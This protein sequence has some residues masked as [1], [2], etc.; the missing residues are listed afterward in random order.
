MTN[1]TPLGDALA[2][3][4]ETVVV[5]TKPNC[6]QCNATYR[7]LDAA[8]ISYSIIDLTQDP[9][10]MNMVSGLGYRQAPVVKCGDDH[11]AGFQP[12]RISKLK[13]RLAAVPAN[14][15]PTLD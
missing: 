9:D 8:G 2:P 3:P 4:D 11:W 14:D 7:G 13:E 12:Q 1:I 10:A 5:Y 6:V 15:T